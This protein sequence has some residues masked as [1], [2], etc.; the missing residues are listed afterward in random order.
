MRVELGGPE[1]FVVLGE[2]YGFLLCVVVNECSYAPSG[3]FQTRR[4]YISY[5]CRFTCGPE[6]G[7]PHMI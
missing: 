2:Q 5:F 4:L 3:P 6:A 1:F 7:F